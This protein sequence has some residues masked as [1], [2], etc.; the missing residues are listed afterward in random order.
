MADI[1]LKDRNGKDVQYPGVNYLK[2]KTVGGGTQGFATYDPETLTAENIKSG[3]A[4]GDVVGKIL[5]PDRE[6]KTIDLDFSKS[7]IMT[8]MPSNND[9]LLF[10]ESGVPFA[11]NPA[12]YN[13]CLAMD[14]SGFDFESGSEYQVHW[15]GAVHNCVAYDAAPIDDLVGGTGAVA[16]G[17]GAVFNLQ[18]NNEPFVFC[19]V[20]TDGSRM[21]IFGSLL[22]TSEAT[23]DVKI[24][25]KIDSGKEKLLSKVNIIKPANLVPENIPKDMEIAGVIGT[26]EGGGAI[27]TLEEKDVCFYDYDGTCLYSYTMEEALALTELPML[28]SHDGLICQGWTHTLSEM[29]SYVSQY[30][31]C[32]I[33]VYYITDDGSTRVHIEITDPTTQTIKFGTVTCTVTNGATVDWGD[34]ATE[35]AKGGATHSYASAGSYII[36]MHVAEGANVTLWSIGMTPKSI[37]KRVEFGKAQFDLGYCSHVECVNIPKDF[38]YIGSVSSLSSVE[39]VVI[40]SN[41]QTTSAVMSV[42]CKKAIFSPKVNALNTNM[43]KNCYN[44]QR[45][46]IPP[47]VT[48]IPNYFMQYNNIANRVSIPEGVTSIGN[49]AFYNCSSLSKVKIPP[50]VTSLGNSVFN[51]C[52][53]LCEVD[54]SRHTSVPSLGSTGFANV[55]ATC[56]ILVPSSL[57]SSW[58]AATNWKTY[59]S[60]I[61]AV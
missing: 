43:F 54:F 53:G 20:L 24:Y 32:D 57:A 31:F 39:A 16:V 8:V 35:I 36:K 50:S 19:T 52:Y 27:A 25:K 33:G 41:L 2:V 9:E 46:A 11:P 60:L 30:D 34:G 4:I 22:D 18:G 10:D 14:A 38:P 56:K 37:I 6:E 15:D 51:G 55:H 29:Q 59:A 61:V 40:P 48:A 45:L 42:Y 12:A 28:P 5:V 13:M 44:N 7:N 49:S 21:V 58:K 17:N 23:H 26:M 3:V 47:L 1:V